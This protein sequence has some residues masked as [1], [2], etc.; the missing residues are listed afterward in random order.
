MSEIWLSRLDFA[1]LW[2][3]APALIVANGVL[4]YDWLNRPQC[5]EVPHAAA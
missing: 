2:I 3:V 5:A 1:L 4:L